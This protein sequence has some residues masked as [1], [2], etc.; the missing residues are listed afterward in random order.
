[1]E[2]QPVGELVEEHGGTLP[3][4]L[5]SWGL[6]EHPAVSSGA[7][8]ADPIGGCRESQEVVNVERTDSFRLNGKDIALPVC[9]VFEAENGEVKAW[10]DYYDGTPFVQA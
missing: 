10:S 5:Q 4:R 7:S 2:C 8:T 9:G 6:T 1:V 3:T